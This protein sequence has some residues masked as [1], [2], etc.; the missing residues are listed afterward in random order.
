VN[1]ERPDAPAAD[2]PRALR[3]LSAFVDFGDGDVEAIRRTAPLVI[4]HE[5][6]LTAAVYEHFLEHPQ[7]ARFFLGEDGAPDTERLE[8]RRHSLGRWLRASAEAALDKQTAYYLLGI[9]LSHSHRT[10]GRGG[11]VP[12]DLMIGAVSLIQTALARLFASHMSPDEALTAAIAWNKLL[13]VQLS[14]FLVG[15]LLPAPAPRI[16]PPSGS[17]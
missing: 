16:D 7:A 5:A 12:A 2:L 17:R 9:G 11:A 6:P 13:L 8:R 1:E 10:W 14:V 4:A 15:Y 3:E